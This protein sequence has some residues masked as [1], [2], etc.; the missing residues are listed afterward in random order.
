MMCQVCR[1][2]YDENTTKLNVSDC[3]DVTAIPYLPLL[4]DLRCDNSSI[5]GI[6]YL[7]SLTYLH[8]NNKYLYNPNNNSGTQGNI[9]EA[10]YNILKKYQKRFRVLRN[11]RRFLITR[12]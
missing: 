7:P 3:L 1:G 2:D 4:A 8:C 6:P 12:E 10:Q 11:I 9:T 5:A